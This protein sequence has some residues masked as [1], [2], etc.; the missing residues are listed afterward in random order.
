MKPV[1]FGRSYG[2]KVNTKEAGDNYF[3]FGS[4]MPGRNYNSNST[5]YGFNGMEKVDELHGNSGDAYDFG[6]RVYD[7][8]LGRWMSVDPSAKFAY[9]ESP[10]VAMGNNPQ[11]NVDPDG[12]FKIPIHKQIMEDALKNADI[13][14]GFLGRFHSDLLVGATRYAD[15]Y[16]ST[17]DHHFDGRKD[18]TAVQKTWEKLNKEIATSL[19]NI[20]ALNK[21]F[22][23]S[24]VEELGIQLHTVQDFY[25]HSNYV[26][27]YIEYYQSAN[28]G[29]MPT[30][31]PIYQEGLKIDGFK[32][33]ME[34]T[35]TD[36]N[37]KYL[38]LHTGEFDLTDNEFYDINPTGDNHTGTDSHKHMNKDEADTDAGKL[39]KKVATTHTE[40]ILNNLK[41]KKEA[42]KEK[43]K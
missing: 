19:I 18:F 43:Q 37:G 39:A 35:T 21:K 25:S 6:A 12:K 3:T 31:V 23:G 41:D 30:E 13:P 8:R 27:L 24:D 34:R 4:L 5:R 40:Y 2:K 14:S 15:V 11:L 38:G 29:V 36:A 1:Y 9:D 28:N 32:K 17:N 16:G 20:G 26:E 42:K 7:A 33:L 22:G 10:F